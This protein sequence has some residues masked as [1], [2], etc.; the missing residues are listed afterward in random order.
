[1]STASALSGDT[2]TTWVRPSTA[3]P[4][5]AARYSA[6]MHTRN[7]ASV[8]PDPVGAAISVS[9]PAAMWGH[10]SCWGGVGPS[11]NRP[12]NHSRTAGWNPAMT[13]SPTPKSAG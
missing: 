10:P 3:S 9:S 1:M 12:S 11:G 13:S 2:Y 8:L 7:P 4:R 5:S 6:S